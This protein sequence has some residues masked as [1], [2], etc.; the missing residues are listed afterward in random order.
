MPAPKPPPSSQPIDLNRDYPCP[1]RRQGRLV[2]I[3]LTE[4]LGCDRCQQIFTVE[5]DGHSITQ[6]VNSYA[7]R[8]TW[9]WSGSQWM[10]HRPKL[11]KNYLPAALCVILVLLVVWLPLALHSAD[12]AVWLWIA[13]AL[14]LAI[15]PALMLWLMYRR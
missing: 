12:T 7:Y 3:T 13:I 8:R 6:L 2:P 1:C 9:R 5:E 14:L 10:V 4:A 11:S 15:L